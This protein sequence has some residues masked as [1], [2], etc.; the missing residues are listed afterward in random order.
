MFSDYR[1]HPWTTYK[2]DQ[3]CNLNLLVATI[4]HSSPYLPI[5]NSMVIANLHS[6]GRSKSSRLSWSLWNHHTEIQQYPNLSQ[7]MTWKI[8]IVSNSNQVQ[9]RILRFT[10]RNTRAQG[11]QPSYAYSNH[12]PLWH[13]LI[14]S[15]H[16][17]DG[18]LEVHHPAPQVSRQHSWFRLGFRLRKDQSPVAHPPIDR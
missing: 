1:H 5:E 4:N 16:L 10:L 9:P 13:L 18:D 2:N 14:R 17:R 7:A 11:Y 6:N 15:G 12:P 8:L 3:T